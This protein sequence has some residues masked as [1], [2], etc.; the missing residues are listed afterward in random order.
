MLQRITICVLGN[1]YSYDNATVYMLVNVYPHIQPLLYQRQGAES[2]L[3]SMA[4]HFGP[5]L[6]SSLPQLLSF[7]SQPL[8]KLPTVTDTEEGMQ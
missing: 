1:V 7:I 8:D 3:I 2:A 4:R 6:F 5:A